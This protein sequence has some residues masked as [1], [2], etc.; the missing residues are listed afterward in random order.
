MREQEFRD[1]LRGTM[2]AASP[3]PPMSSVMMLAAARR[4][5]LRR[6]TVWAGAGSAAA[7]LTIFTVSV[8]PGGS[9]PGLTAG[10]PG[11]AH[12]NPAPGTNARSAEPLPTGPGGRPQ[13]DRTA[14]A[15]V[16]YE[17]G[18]RLLE[19]LIAAV[20]AGYTTPEKAAAGGG[21]DGSTGPTGAVGSPGPT[22]SGESG[23][24]GS[25]DGQAQPGSIELPLRDHQA[26][27]DDRV[28]GVELWTYMAST[29]VAKDGGTGRML[30]EVHV[31]GSDLPTEPCELAQ[32]FWGMKGQCQV[33]DSGTAKVGVVTKPDPSDQRFDQWAAYRAPEGKVVY[34]AQRARF[35]EVRQPLAT[36]P[37]SIAQLA[38]LATHEEL[39]VD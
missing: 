20:P 33:V 37:L 29:A 2:A 1:A 31:P 21:S 6:R 10:G 17:Q 23:T 5:Q 18:E 22:G 36:L 11:A 30:A 7:A 35:D 38:A 3:P 13:E 19:A 27:F 28:N 8:L 26:N 15:G 32:Q 24:P 25:Q 14:R 9:D 16:R 4:A 12:T 34:V 39:R